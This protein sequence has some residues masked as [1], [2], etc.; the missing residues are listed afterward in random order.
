M[1]RDALCQQKVIML[2]TNAEWQQSAVTFPG[3]RY[4][5]YALVGQQ[6]MMG[7]NRLMQ[8]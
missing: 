3:I 1:L 5:T 4:S 8:W 2:W 6:Y 7:T